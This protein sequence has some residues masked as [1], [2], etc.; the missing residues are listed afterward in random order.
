[1][2]KLLVTTA[3]DLSSD[4]FE[5]HGW[6]VL[7][8]GLN[9]SS[10]KEYDVVYFR[11]PF[12]D[13]TVTKEAVEKS[14][15]QIKGKRSIDGVQAFSDMLSCEDKYNQARIY[16]DLMPITYLPSEQEFI[17]GKHIAKKRISQRSKDILFDIDG[18][19]IDDNWIFQEI[20]DIKEELRVYIVF[21]KVVEYATIKS[22]KASGKVKVI[23]KRTLSEK[24]L[25]FCQKVSERTNLDFVGIDVAVLEGGEL[26]L[27][28]VNR[29]PQFK[30]FVELYGDEPLM[31]ILNL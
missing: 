11:D 7:Q 27:I 29:S 31:G 24:E 4:V 18:V 16:Q 14:L 23:G 5:K 1:M 12:N 17:K 22:S 3:K 8:Y 20:M 25:E 28:E 26:A 2:Q 6:D 13:D 10:D 19:A 30:R 15:G 21:G 9:L